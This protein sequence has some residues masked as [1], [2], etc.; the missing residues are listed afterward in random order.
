MLRVPSGRSQGWG[1]FGV[2]GGLSLTAFF[3]GFMERNS[4]RPDHAD[5]S[6]DVDD[7]P[8][9]RRSGGVRPRLSG[10]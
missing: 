8:R 9:K 5:R 4:K 10:Y 7:T 6:T 1:C 2:G 3:G